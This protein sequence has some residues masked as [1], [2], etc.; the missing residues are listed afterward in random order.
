MR[1]A[2]SREDMLNAQAA[3]VHLEDITEE[4][5]AKD[6]PES[7]RWLKANQEVADAMA[8]LSA[9]QEIEVRD[10]VATNRPIK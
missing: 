8:R 9:L 10:A 4:D 1:K 7:D 6:S 3:L 5:Q 2:G